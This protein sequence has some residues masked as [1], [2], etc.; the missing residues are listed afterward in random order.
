[1]LNCCSVI[2]AAFYSPHFFSLSTNEKKKE[3]KK[4]NPCGNYPGDRSTR[5]VNRPYYGV[6]PESASGNTYE[7]T[8]KAGINPVTRFVKVRAACAFSNNINVSF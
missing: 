7:S 2:K 4:K 8:G 6:F 5:S 3:T 1:M